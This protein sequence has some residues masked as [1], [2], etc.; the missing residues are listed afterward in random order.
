MFVNVLSNF[1][2]WTG[3]THEVGVCYHRH[4]LIDGIKPT[5]LCIVEKLYKKENN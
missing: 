5:Q 2:P 3:E 4:P 1:P